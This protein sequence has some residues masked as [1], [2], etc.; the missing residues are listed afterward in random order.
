MDTMHVTP[1]ELTVTDPVALT[2]ELIDIPSESGNEQRIADAV[3]RALRACDHLEVLRDGDAVLART[4]QGRPSRVLVAGHLDTVP[5]ADNVPHTYRT[6]GKDR[7]LCGRGS[8]DML[9]GVAVA[10][11]AACALTHSTRDV[12]WVF[13]DH[14]EVHASLNGLG[15]IART[16]PEW[17]QEDLA[18]LGEPTAAHI[19]GGCNGTLRVRISAQGKPAHTARAWRGDNAIHTLAPV[20][21]AVAAFGHPERLVDGLAYT[22]SLSVV[23]IGGG[24]GGNVVPDSAHMLVN[25]RFAPCMTGDEALQ[26]IRSLVNEA[27]GERASLCTIEVDDCAEGARP[28]LAGECA[29]EFVEVARKVSAES[30]HELTVHAKLGWTDVARFSALGVPA[31]NYGPGDPLLA[32]TREEHVN[33]VEIERCARTLMAWL[34]ESR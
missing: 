4:T 18:L 34:G 17:L 30:G 8:V 15:R 10:L 14:E 9:G 1:D 5:I 23:G 24:A 12:T 11:H 28:G 22:E 13:Y 2:A 20:I 29:S 27:L 6:R 26:V 25:Y 19:E 21:A 32:H 7:L 31:L 33:I 16:H 3:E